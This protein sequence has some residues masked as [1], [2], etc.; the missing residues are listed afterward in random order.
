M[1]IDNHSH[2]MYN[3][4]EQIVL[5]KDA[6]IDKTI[7]FPTIINPEKANNLIEFENEYKFLLD[8]LSGKTNPDIE[9]IKSINNV[10]ATKDKY[11]DLFWGFGS[12]PYGL[13]YENTFEWIDKYIISNGLIGIGELSFGNGSVNKIE[14]IF[15]VS[16]DLKNKLPLWIHSFNPLNLADIKEIIELALKYPSVPVILGHGGGYYWMET[17]KL[18]KDIKNIYIDTSA[19]FNIFSLKYFADEIPERTLF[20]VDAPYGD[21]KISKNMIE[22]I[23][24]DEYVRRL[25]LGEN[26]LRLINN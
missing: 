17:L 13:N 19:S 24:K 15:K 23:I 3:I 22:S 5:M 6:G 1:I 12:C 4:D 11:K 26:I 18:T 7:L 2:L 16:F 25:I 8:V 21:L 10:A 20:G 14:N 9:R